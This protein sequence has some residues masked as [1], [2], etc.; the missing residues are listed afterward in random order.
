MSTITFNRQVDSPATTAEYF[1]ANNYIFG[2]NSN[3]SARFEQPH[4]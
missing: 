1:G 4:R 2:G 3:V